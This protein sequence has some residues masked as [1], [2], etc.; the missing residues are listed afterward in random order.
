[1][2]DTED[3]KLWRKAKAR[4][5]FRVHFTVY[6]CVT[7]FMW[8]IWASIDMSSHPWPIYLMFAWGIGIFFH[9]LEAYDY[10]NKIA[11]KEYDKMKN[12]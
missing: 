4:M 5:E 8:V 7:A 12:Q 9:F 6:L 1:M 3:S 11:R 2:K 10:F